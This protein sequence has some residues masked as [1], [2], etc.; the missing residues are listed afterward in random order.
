MKLYLS[1]PMTGYPA[2]N[3]PAFEAAAKNLRALGH[4]VTSP[5]ELD[6]KDAI[7]EIVRSSKDGNV[8]ELTA[9]TGQTW[10]TLL[11]RDVQ[12][13]ADGNFDAI[14]VLPGWQQ[15]K[16]AKLEVIVGLLLRLPIVLY[17][18]EIELSPISVMGIISTEITE[19][20]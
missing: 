13:L 17:G 7:G 4:E 6:E 2:F 19:G 20:M 16:G 12:T 14:V 5:H 3:V 9:Q 15:S 10:G 11:A 8:A 1:G 18:K